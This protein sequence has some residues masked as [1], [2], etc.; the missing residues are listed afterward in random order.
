M[1][2]QL[3]RFVQNPAV[4]FLKRLC[5]DPVQLYVIMLVTTIMEYYHSGWTWVYTLVCTFLTF[6]LMK[7]YDFV[8]A[9]KYLGPV[10]YLGFLVLGLIAVWIL[11]EI[12]Y[13]N[14]PIIFA[15]WFLTP[16]SAVDFSL[17][18]TIAIF[19]LMT[20]FLSSAV[21][22]FGKVRYRMVMQFL[23]MLIPLSMYAKEGL[24]MD[25][26]LVIIL[27]ASYF[28]LMIWCR[29]LRDTPDIRRVP[30]LQTGMSV[31]VYVTA[32]SIL[33]AVIP[34][35]SIKADREFIENAMGN[36]SL[37]DILMEAISVFSDSTDNSMMFT[38]NTRTVYYVHSPEPLRMRTQ[39]YTYY[40]ADDSWNKLQDYDYATLEYTEEAFYQP[41]ALLQAIL[42]AAKA[43][44]EFAENYGL[45]DCI[46]AELPEQKLREVTVIHNLW[47]GYLM[48]TPTRFMS[49]PD[50]QKPHTEMTPHDAITFSDR[51]YDRG[52][53]TALLYYS[54]TYANYEQ[55][56]GILSMID[57]ETYSDLLWDAHTV[58]QATDTEASELLYD[59]FYEHMDAQIYL[60][61]CTKL[62]YQS[63]AL[64]A[65]AME[66]TEGLDSDY[67]KAKA[68]ERY[69]YE[70]DFVYDMSYQKGRDD[71]IEAFLFESKRG[72]CYE[73]ATAMVML[74]RSAGIPARYVQGY[75]MT[76]PYSGRFEETEI[77]YLIKARD[78]HGFP[79]VYIPGYGWLSFEPTVPMTEEEYG[80]AAENFYVMLWGFVLLGLAVLAAAG[81][82][83]APHV[84]EWYFRRSLSRMQPAQAA[85]AIFRRM[86]RL[87]HLPDSTTVMALA[88]QSAIFCQN[89]A[90][91][92][93][94]NALLYDT[95][96]ETPMTAE[97]L[98]NEYIQWQSARTAYHKEQ[99]AKEKKHR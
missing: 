99:K 94:M 27:L 47:G 71:N 29:Q 11:T 92:E 10:C 2:N 20:G 8:A 89:T 60:E 87:L 40:L 36:S 31:A 70:Q 6:L 15:I 84:Q 39:T 32:F 76:E 5:G 18:Y 35:P 65:L 79:E 93:A 16:Q 64:D 78:S 63:D 82:F 28:L 43:D 95:D 19:V 34:K 45:T 54:D 9:H 17:W 49:I 91:F 41:R 72:I 1:W 51:P 66:L 26:L 23:I 14:Y 48:P 25:A 12:G 50:W 53:V 69:F 67:E 57:A 55:V 73:F 58:L 90:L 7:F 24:Q 68:I 96:A 59:C 22:Y 38:N 74:C 52:T 61:K 33:A 97:A 86:R 83:L 81:Y 62:D 75:N 4:Q 42:D 30:S 77:N 44:A 80:S 13:S 85:A 3:Q 46:T 56:A 88:E 98:R 37:S 21:Y